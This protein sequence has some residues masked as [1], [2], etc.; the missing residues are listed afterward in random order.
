[1]R[2][3]FSACGLFMGSSNVTFHLQSMELQHHPLVASAG[4]TLSVAV[5]AALQ[6]SLP[7][8][9][10]T[11]RFASAKLLG[12]I[13]GL[14]ADYLVAIGEDEVGE[15][16]YFYCVDGVSWA[17]L[18]TASEPER[19][20]CSRL[21]AGL[22]FTGDPS[23]SLTLPELEDDAAEAE[24]AE[25]PSV[26]EEVRLAVTVEQI[27]NECAMV[28]K[29][30]LAPTAWGGFRSDPSFGGI[31]AEAALNLSSYVL[32]NCKAPKAGPMA[33]SADTLA[34][35]DSTVPAGALCTRLDPATGAA[36]VRSLLF[37]GFVAYCQPNT[38]VYGYCY[39]GDGK[40]NVDIP[41]MLP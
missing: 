19:A 33:F 32:R 9:C 27:E 29:G 6:S 8:L 41:F 16:R 5:R 30:A 36:L 14:S 31:K 13:W 25:P 20:L 12:Q 26:S 40:K 4:V 1:M 21:P 10:Q 11:Q 15:R 35:A 38:P 7:L 2:C 28:P 17:A 18:P 22:P 39:F 3:P 34:S 37:P 23:H 24:P